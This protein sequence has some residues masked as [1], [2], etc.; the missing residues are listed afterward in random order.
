LTKTKTKKISESEE[1]ALKEIPF[2]DAV[3]RLLQTPPSPKA[4]KSPPEKSKE[5]K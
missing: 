5:N 2:E 3:K 4:K 1:S